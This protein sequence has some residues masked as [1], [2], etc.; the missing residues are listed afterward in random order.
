VAAA[1]LNRGAEEGKNRKPRLSD[2]KGSGQIEQDAD[3]A[4]LIFN[5]NRG[6][7]DEQMWLCVEKNRD[8]ATGD[9]PVYF[10]KPKMRIVGTGAA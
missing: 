7:A 2:F 8:G 5:Q 1:Q 4:M 10:D 3:V 9:V 6:E